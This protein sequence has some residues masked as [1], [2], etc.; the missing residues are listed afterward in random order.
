LP[1]LN[2][3][4]GHVGDRINFDF[5]LRMA[6]RFEFACKARAIENRSCIWTFALTV[7]TIVRAGAL[8]D[9]PSAKSGHFLPPAGNGLTSA[10]LSLPVRY[11]PLLEFL[12]HYH[13][14]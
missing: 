10:R 3:R 1:K 6:F 9:S 5:G 4:S 2:Y 13:R 14:H 7:A 8:A 11:H 12:P